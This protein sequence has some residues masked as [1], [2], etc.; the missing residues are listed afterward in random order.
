MD[1]QNVLREYNK[2]LLKQL[3]QL[4]ERFER[5]SGCDESRMKE[6]EDGDEQRARREAAGARARAAPQKPTVRFADTCGQRRSIQRSDPPPSRTPDYRGGTP[7][8][9]EDPHL[10]KRPEDRRPLTAE[11]CSVSDGKDRLEILS[12]VALH[13]NECEDTPVLE[14]HHLKPLLGYDWI[15]GVLDSDDSV[16]ER[17]DEFFNDLCV[18]RS[19]HKGECIHGAQT[20]FS[21]EGHSVPPLLID[22]D[23]PTDN[24]EVHHCT[25]S[26]RINSRLF[27]V[28]LHSQECCPVC[29]KHKS[30]HPHTAAEPA[31]VRVSIPRTAL[32]PSYKYRAHRRRSFDPSDSLALTSNCLL[33]WSNRGQSSLPPPS[34]LDLRSCLK[35]KKGSPDGELQDLPVLKASDIQPLDQISQLSCLARH[36]FQ[37]FS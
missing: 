24:M 19:L 20:E 13:T 17:S 23:D 31:L 34:S 14:R 33:G 6:L 3:R 21:E 32:L 35:T 26:Y 4:G 30:S 11:R 37:H 7:E 18:F 2:D 5:L 22:K 12:R 15:A 28:P 27:P 25:F 1:R 36:N 9:P 8:H 29:R 16:L 10:R